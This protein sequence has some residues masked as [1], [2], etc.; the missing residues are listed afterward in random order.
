MPAAS[1]IA[2]VGPA[3]LLVLL[4]TKRDAAVPSIACGN[5]DEGFVNKLHD[6][7]ILETQTEKPC[8]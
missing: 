8:E 7:I 6:L 5:V 2:T 1:A 3:E 4:V